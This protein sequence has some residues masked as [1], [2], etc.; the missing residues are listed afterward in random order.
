MVV[1]FH[2]LAGGQ[3]PGLARLLPS[4]ECARWANANSDVC[5]AQHPSKR[6]EAIQQ[7]SFCRDCLASVLVLNGKLH[8]VAM[9]QL[10]IQQL[11]PTQLVWSD[12]R[13]HKQSACSFERLV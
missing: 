6:V 12:R 11:R 8:A 4:S 1:G 7:E 2:K 5:A 10:C 13:P 9:D 3:A